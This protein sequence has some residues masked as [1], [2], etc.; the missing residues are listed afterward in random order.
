LN[1]A[2]AFYRDTRL[3]ENAGP[4]GGESSQR[5][6]GPMPRGRRIIEIGST[7]LLA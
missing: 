2:A 6:A 3:R 1:I 4:V 7:G 5:S